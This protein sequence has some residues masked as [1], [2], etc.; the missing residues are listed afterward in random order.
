MG[1]FIRRRRPRA[2]ELGLHLTKGEGGVEAAIF[3]PSGKGIPLRLER[4]EPDWA[5]TAVRDLANELGVDVAVMDDAG[6]W[7]DL[8]LARDTG[9]RTAR[10]RDVSAGETEPLAVRFPPSGCVPRDSR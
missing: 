9:S 1:S 3:A 5:I 7:E 2:H 6:V 10:D 4:M 8:S